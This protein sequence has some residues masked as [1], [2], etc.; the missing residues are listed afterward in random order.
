MKSEQLKSGNRPDIGLFICYHCIESGIR[1]ATLITYKPDDFVCF[2]YALC[3]SIVHY[4]I[5]SY[6]RDYSLVMSWEAA[7]E[8]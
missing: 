8:E 6:F 1:S 5:N 2:I 7:V 3:G 4:K